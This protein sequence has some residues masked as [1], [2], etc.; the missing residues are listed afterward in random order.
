MFYRCDDIIEVDLSKFNS[1]QVKYTDRMFAYCTSL[2]S[3]N[4]TNFKTSQVINM[5]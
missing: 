4:L 1:T 3:V 5:H 2:T